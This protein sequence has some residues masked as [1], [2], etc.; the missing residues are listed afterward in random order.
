MA[1]RRPKSSAERE[2]AGGGGHR[3]LPNDPKPEAGWP[4]L[5]PGMSAGARKHFRRLAERLEHER[6]LTKSDGPGL[7]GAARLYDI[8]IHAT[9]RA[10]RAE[11]E[12]L[13]DLAR[14]ARVEERLA[15]DSYRKWLNDL[16]LTP[17]TRARARVSADPGDKPN[18]LASLQARA[19]ALRRPVAVG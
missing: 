3:P 5:P 1:G 11:R 7:E 8:A 4:D 10:R 18:K 19:A 14:E 15:W 17:G 9:K 2:L 13:Y 16:T 12:G 6:R